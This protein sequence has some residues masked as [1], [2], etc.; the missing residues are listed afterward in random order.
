LFSNTKIDKDVFNTHKRSNAQYLRR[1]VFKER[2]MKTGTYI[3][4]YKSLKYCQQ[5]TPYIQWH[6]LIENMG[7]KKRIGQKRNVTQKS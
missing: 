3:T 7:S 4:K 6:L 2:T 5:S 1:F